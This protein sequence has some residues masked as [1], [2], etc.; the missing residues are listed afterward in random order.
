MTKKIVWIIV[1]IIIVIL[2]VVIAQKP[3]SKQNSAPIKIG[4]VASLTGDAAPWGES[5]KNGVDLAVKTINERGGLN[6]RQ[7][8]VI[9]EDDHTNGKDAVSA[10]NKLVNV[11][12]VS[13]VIGSVFDFTTQ[14]LLPLAESNKVAL[15]SPSNFRIAGSFELGEQSFVMLIN[16][17]DLIRYFND[18]LGQDKV[19]KLAIVHFTSTWGVEITKTVTE[20][21][22]SYG[23]PKPIE[24]AYT[25]IGGNDFR[26]TV[27]KLKNVGVDTVFFD[28]LGEDTVNFLKR[29]N[30]LG[31][32]PTMLT[33]IGSMESFDQEKDKSLIENVAVVNWEVSSSEFN[34]LYEKEYGKPAGKSADKAFDALYVMATAIA[35][36]KSS[37]EVAP[38]ISGNTFTTPNATVRF[39]PDHTVNSTPVEIDIVKDGK[40]VRWVR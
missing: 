13:G 9:T 21:M 40:L 35:N 26:T 36:T 5:A 31:F 32:K 24:E 7:V 39:M 12:G 25:K 1:A 28:M 27:L 22:E 38:Y 6:G 37:S 34:A 20:I 3:A 16:F 19:K 8:Q 10:Y 17:S 14:P 30:E 29:S 2:I 15:I 4:L 18:F 33:Y 11:D 23:K